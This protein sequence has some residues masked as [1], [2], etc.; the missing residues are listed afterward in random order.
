MKFKEDI[1]Y[2]FLGTFLMA[3]GVNSFFESHNLVI[4]GASGLAILMSSFF[5]GLSG[6]RI[7]LWVLF[8]M[9]NVPLFLAGFWVLGFNKLKKSF[10]ATALLSFM[11]W[12]TGFLPE[13][14]TDLPI[15]AVFGGIIE[16][17][18]LGLVLRTGFTTG[19]SDL[20][21]TVINKKLPR[22]SVS[23]LILIVD[24]IIIALG[25]FEFG[26][27]NAFYAIISVFIAVKM[28]DFFVMGAGFAKAVYIISDKSDE[29]GKAIMSNLERGVTTL[30][31]RGEYTGKDKNIILCVVS[32]KQVVGIKRLTFTLD[33]HAF[34]LITP[35]AEVTGEGFITPET[36]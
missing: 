8:F 17:A 18:G 21:A 9:I 11:L 16:G 4:G 29:I 36:D 35:A 13:F 23:F 33:P 6:V 32:K 10:F 27:I 34:I 24:Y 19:G 15:A 26:S 28:I 12:A 5:Y 14:E 25:F 7:P 20:L 3:V 22:F 30:K 1:V 2:I 31:G